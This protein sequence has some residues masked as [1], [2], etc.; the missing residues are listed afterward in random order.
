MLKLEYPA[1]KSSK[2]TKS[3]RVGFGNHFEKFHAN[4]ESA[5]RSQLCRLEVQRSLRVFGNVKMMF[6][7]F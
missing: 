3:I 6:K 4:A 2:S 5:E 7:E 1:R